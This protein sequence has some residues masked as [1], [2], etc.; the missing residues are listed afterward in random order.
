MSQHG[1]TIPC[2]E[3]NR[4]FECRMD[5]YNN[6]VSIFTHAFS[7]FHVLWNNES[8]AERGRD[9]AFTAGSEAIRFSAPVE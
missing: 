4:K 8:I 9:P 6:Y 5:I 2:P 1:G 3:R 7:S